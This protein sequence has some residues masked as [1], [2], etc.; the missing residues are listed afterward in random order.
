M[1]KKTPYRK[2]PTPGWNV[3]QLLLDLHQLKSMLPLDLIWGDNSTAHYQSHKVYQNT[4]R[5]W[6][7]LSHKMS[8]HTPLDLPMS[9]LIFGLSSTNIEVT[10][11]HIL[12]WQLYPVWVLLCQE[13]R[14][15]GTSPPQS[16]WGGDTDQSPCFL[17]RS[18]QPVQMTCNNNVGLLS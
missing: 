17:Y 18:W 15:P 4:W 1:K 5:N 8:A 9:Y 12:T 7:R 6:R 2:Y 13:S 10:T 14:A 3:K 11:E 16:A